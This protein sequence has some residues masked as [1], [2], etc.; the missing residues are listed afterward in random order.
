[1]ANMNMIIH[2]MEAEEADNG[3][4]EIPELCALAT[5]REIFPFSSNSG[6][7]RSDGRI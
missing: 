6:K 2:D 3:L 5:L 1:M 4:W 7:R